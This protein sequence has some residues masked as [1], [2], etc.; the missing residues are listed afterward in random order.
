L[1]LTNQMTGHTN[2]G[3]S[4][5][6]KSEEDHVHYHGVDRAEEY[7]HV[8]EA[9]QLFL[10]GIRPHATETVSIQESNN[11]IAA[12][13]IEAPVDLPRLARSTR[14]GYAL[15]ISRDISPTDSSSGFKIVGAVR[16]GI[17][18]KFRLREKEAVRIATGS[19]IPAGANA[20]VMVEYSR[21]DGGR[22]FVNNEI[23]I[24]QNMLRPGE[25][26]KKG[27]LLIRTGTRIHPQH[28]ALFSMLGITQLKVF[29]KPRVA[30]FSTGDELTDVSKSKRSKS[31]GSVQIFDS[32]RPFLNSIIPELGAE[33]VDL[34]IA[35]DDLS[36]IRTKMRKGLR[37]DALILTAGSSVGERDYV[38]K[39][40]AQIKGMNV[41]VHGVAMRPS[42][43]TGLASFKGRPL[44][45]LPGFPTS[46]IVSFY[47]FGRPAI[48]KL[49]G[50]L[51]TE[52]ILIR[53]T[54]EDRFTGKKGIR[55]FIRV[56][57]TKNDSKYMA[58]ICRPTEAQYSSWLHEANGI[59]IVAEEHSDQVTEPGSEVPV[60]LI[61]DVE[62]S[63]ANPH[64]DYPE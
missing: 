57:V 47:V 6:D 32:N 53:A 59:A 33:P 4:D 60:F 7:I 29:S 62:D 48:L 64:A 42:S 26:I 37:Y 52:P 49:T 21:T 13:D 41:L 43:P 16:I 55:H 61:G 28:V 10:G 58:K 22:L 46:A 36:A 23:K 19:F 45:L 18:P 25:D 40:A 5:S 54:L 8:E 1:K 12:R 38:G 56:R 17:V 2:H 44:I 14:D 20:V 50:S 15:N 3:S 9:L 51:S 30:F 11:R 27:T 34:G 63:S 39:A 24:G 31:K 35:K